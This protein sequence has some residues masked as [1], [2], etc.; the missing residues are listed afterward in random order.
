MKSFKVLGSIKNH[1]LNHA[2]QSTHLAERQAR[3]KIYLDT[4]DEGVP[5]KSFIVDTGHRNGLERHIIMS[6]GLLY[7]YNLKTDKLIT[8]WR[9]NSTQI[10]RYFDQLGLKMTCKAKRFGLK[11]DVLNK[12]QKTNNFYEGR[13]TDD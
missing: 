12:A 10:K 4:A 9:P 7:I 11:N 3:T 13:N 8:L 2:I 5:Y 6:N 1:N